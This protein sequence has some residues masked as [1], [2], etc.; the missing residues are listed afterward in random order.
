MHVVGQ[1]GER[2]RVGELAVVVGEL[3]Q[4]AEAVCDRERREGA[5]GLTGEYAS[6]SRK[7]SVSF[8]LMAT[9]LIS[10]SGS[11]ACCTCSNRLLFTSGAACRK[12]NAKH[13][14]SGAYFVSVGDVEQLRARRVG[15][16][17]HGGR[18]VLGGEHL[19]GA[20]GPQVPESSLA[21]FAGREEEVLGDF[22][23]AGVV[24]VLETRDGV[25]VAHFDGL[26]D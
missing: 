3:L 12:S 11:C 14:V 22:G 5:A 26:Q 2:H 9:R 1:L 16:A 15:Q 20:A 8:L 4:Q 17:V 24:E 21:V 13:W 18:H 6:S 7:S 23:P 10:R 19:D 25:F